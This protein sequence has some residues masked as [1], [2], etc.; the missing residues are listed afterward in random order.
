MITDQRWKHWHCEGFRP[1]LFDLESDPQELED[2]G[3]SSSP[4]HVAVRARMHDA[5]FEWSRRHHNRITRSA[6]EVEHMFKVKEPPGIVIGVWDEAAYEE[7]FGHPFD[8]RPG[9]A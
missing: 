3:A 1:V 8:R 2:L 9:K 4:E 6:G 7:E 5:I